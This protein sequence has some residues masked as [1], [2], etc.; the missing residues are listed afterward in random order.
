MAWDKNHILIT[1]LNWMSS[2][3]SGAFKNNDLYHE[4]GIYV[5]VDKIE[6]RFHANFF[7]NSSHE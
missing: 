6:Q 3:A 4:L 1:N 2:D 7:D 5:K